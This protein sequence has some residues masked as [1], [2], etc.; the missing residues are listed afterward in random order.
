MG[1]IFRII[2]S[3]TNTGKRQKSTSMSHLRIKGLVKAM[4]LAREQLAAGIPL[5]EAEA[6]RSGITGTVAQTEQICREQRCSPAQLPAQ[7]YRAFQFLKQIDLDNLPTR[8]DDRRPATKALRI[9]NLVAI[10]DSIQ[11]RLATLA[12]RADF[13]A[14]HSKV[15]E[16]LADI[17]SHVATVDAIAE[18]ASASPASLPTQSRRAYQWLK[19]LSERANLQLHLLTLVRALKSGGNLL[20]KHKIRYSL[21][22]DLYQMGF[23]Y[24]TRLDGDSI[25]IVASE[26]FAGAPRKVLDALMWAALRGRLG[27][28][29]T[30]ARTR[31]GRTQVQAYAETE[32]FTEVILALELSD[33]ATDANARGQ[34]YDLAQVFARVNTEYFDNRLTTPRLTWNKTLTQRKF[35]HY[36][37]LGDTVMISLTLDEARIPAYVVDFVMY[38]ELLHKQLGIELVGG[39][40]YAHTPEFRARERE[41]RLYAAAQA[42][43]QERARDSA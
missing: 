41:F 16:L 35:G 42:R 36:Q 26:G 3:T 33:A 20:R 5:S 12:A 31:R 1:G 10:C 32:D 27:S 28:P 8:S 21:R 15:T 13:D 24:R 17:Q 38:H 19:F 23:L 2:F 39:R 40:R 4:N 37:P 11:A 14:A 7:S 25:H 22:F 9:K 6:F 29:R 30:P 43:F 18:K 34:H